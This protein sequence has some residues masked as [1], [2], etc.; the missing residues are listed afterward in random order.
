MWAPEQIPAADSSLLQMDDLKI[1]IR[2]LLKTPGF[3]AA[4]IAV[5][6]LGIGLNAAM[7]SVV[8]ALAFAARPFPEPDQL[9]QL[10]SRD[11]RTMRGR[12]FAY[13]VYEDLATRADLFDGLLAHTMT[14]V[15]IGEGAGARRTFSALVSANYFDVLG[16]PMLQGR[17]FTAEEGRARS[18]VPVAVAT[19]TYWKRT[20]F[21][22]ELVGRSVRVNGRV[23][24]IVGI[25]P[26][27]F[28]GTMTV[29]GPE[30]FF[31]LG[32]FD[33]LANDSQG[34]TSRHHLHD[35]AHICFSWAGSPRIGQRTLS[36]AHW[37]ST[38]AASRRP[39]RL[40]TST[41]S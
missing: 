11:S 14:V 26:Q 3:T 22:P 23:F 7:F 9:V 18:D 41:T 21:D 1:S 40:N 4:A 10:Y 17:R 8:H 28:T 34:Q 15:G 13:P 31:P 36:R 38:D 37:H 16:V 39:S 25:T 20:G 12:A 2:Q 30:L 33:S 6:A 5:L 19:Y 32:V 27:G 35:A 24:T 29:F